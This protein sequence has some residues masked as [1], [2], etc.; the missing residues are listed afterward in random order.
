MSREEIKVWVLTDD[1]DRSL[2][3]DEI[4]VVVVVEGQKLR[5]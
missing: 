3:D 2:E 1:E 5:Q 4:V